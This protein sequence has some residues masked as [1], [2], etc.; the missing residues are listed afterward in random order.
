MITKTAHSPGWP[1]G[2]RATGTVPPG[3]DQPPQWRKHG[4]E[5]TLMSIDESWA[6]VYIADHKEQAL[7]AEHERAEAESTAE[8]YRAAIVRRR[9]HN[10][11]TTAAQIIEAATDHSPAVRRGAIAHP[12]C[13]P[14]IRLNGL[15]DA[16]PEVRAEVV[17]VIENPADLPPG[18][19]ANE[20]WQVRAALAER[21][22]CSA[23]I[24]IDLIQRDPDP[25][26]RRRALAAGALRRD[27]VWQILCEAPEPVGLAAVSIANHSL[28]AAPDFIKSVPHAQ[29]REAIARRPGLDRNM[30]L[31]LAFQDPDPGVRAGA[32]SNTELSWSLLPRAFRDPEPG[33]REAAVLRVG[34]REDLLDAAANDASARVRL[35]ALTHVP[36]DPAIPDRLST[37][38][39]A[40]VRAAACRHS[41][42]PAAALA[43]AVVD[44]DVSVRRAAVDN[45]SMP[46][47]ALVRG[48]ADHDHMIRYSSLAHPAVPPAS[49]AFG[50]YRES[51]AE[52]AIKVQADDLS[53]VT[54]RRQAQRLNEAAAV[55]LTKAPWDELQPLPLT[56]LPQDLIKRII[57]GHLDQAVADRRVTI[58]RLVAEHSAVKAT[59]LVALCADT[60]PRVRDAAS[61]RVVDA[62]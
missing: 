44:P 11:G 33:P 31:W 9:L 17:R 55:A 46:R 22:D 1:S 48:C 6:G 57:A 56:L 42:C 7:R 61:A 20:H 50:V 58:R 62:L 12:D 27:V 38:G 34:F 21:T 49:A 30:L 32:V 45:P 47:S 26:V 41:N 13:P 28:D 8:R 40:E 51:L 59:H 25:E 16:D 37:D 54:H 4:N 36:L 3:D 60:V 52:L 10:P 18:T 29:V 2:N 39:D 35:A 14:Q 19:V 5:D 15:I 23:Q 24:V 43:V 53:A